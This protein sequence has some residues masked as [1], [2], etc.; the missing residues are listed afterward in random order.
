MDK[1]GIENEVALQTQE[2]LKDIEWQLYTP[3]ERNDEMEKL[4]NRS[5]D[6]VKS[7]QTCPL[8]VSR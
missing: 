8:H 7:I 5:Q 1:A 2:L 3:F 4:Y 6:L